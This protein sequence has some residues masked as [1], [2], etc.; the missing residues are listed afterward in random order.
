M[1]FEKQDET[2]CPQCAA[3]FGPAHLPVGHLG[4]TKLSDLPSQ[5]HSACVQVTLIMLHMG[6]KAREQ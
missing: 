2:V 6:P 1:L 3:S 4:A 5:D